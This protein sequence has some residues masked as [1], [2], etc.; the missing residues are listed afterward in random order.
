M[1]RLVTTTIAWASPI[2]IAATLVAQQPATEFDPAAVE[3]G[4]QLL[5]AQC[6]FCHGAN[7]RGGSSGP[8]LTRSALVQTDEGGRQLGQFLRVGRPDRG[9]PAFDFT[10]AQMADLAVFLHSAIRANANRKAYRILDVL[11]GD[12]KAGEA[13]FNG[14]GR[15]ATCHSPQRDLRGIGAKYDPPMLQNRMVLPRGGATAPNTQPEP[16][17]LDRN[18]IRATITTSGGES[19]TGAIVRLTDFDVAIY[20]S[21]SGQTRTFLRSGETPK[22]VVTDPLQAH[23]D[24]LAKWTDADMHNVTAYLAGLK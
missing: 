22:V 12:A 9:M 11:V 24:Q 6:G 23:V 10:D 16:A 8:D 15:C 19:I 21:A 20:D 2:L 1:I 7:A 17:H 18:A 3:R 13:Y 4:Q 5:S 14:E